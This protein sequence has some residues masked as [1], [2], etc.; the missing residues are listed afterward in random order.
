MATLR[1][2]VRQRLWRPWSIRS[3][4]LLAV[5]SL[6]AIAIVVVCAATY[7]ALGS[8]L[9]DRL[10][11]QLVQSAPGLQGILGPQGAFGR[12][13]GFVDPEAALTV[14]SSTG[15]QVFALRNNVVLPQQSVTPGGPHAKTVTSSTGRHYRVIAGEANFTDGSAPGS[16]T[17][18]LPISQV[19]N[20]LHRLFLLELAVGGGSIA[21]LILLGAA[22]VR[23][24]LRPLARIGQTAGEIAAGDFSQRVSP[25]TPTTEVGRLGISLNAMLTQI[26]DEIRRRRASEAQLRQFISDASHELRTPLTSIRGYA[27]LFRRGAGDR[28]EDLALAMRRI[29]AESGRMGGLVDDLLLLARLDEGRP[30]ERTEVDLAELARDAVADAEAIDP[31]RGATVTVEGDVHVVGDDARLRQ[32][33]ANLVRN[34]LAHTPPHSPFGV[35][36]RGEADRV[37]CEVWDRGPGLTPQMQAQVFDR[38]WRGDPSRTRESAYAGSGLGLSIVSALVT[39]H[40]GTVGVSP[41]PAGG[42]IFAVTLPRNGVRDL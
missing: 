37:S 11:R 19:D 8:Y 6:A 24:G 7:F 35:R 18:G 12:G 42:A 14:Y 34:V 40:G 41:A 39:A 21:L 23:L 17:Y 29:E 16:V 22:V 20:V 30:L 28:P 1:A 15:T 13:A 5:A 38:F 26:E 33:L 36:L 2:T 3:R 31:E 10:D 25:T 32:V 9:R 4:L 27:E